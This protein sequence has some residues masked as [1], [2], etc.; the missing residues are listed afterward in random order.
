MEKVEKTICLCAIV[1][2][3]EKTLPRLINSCKGIL[4]YWVIIDTGSTDNTISVVKE[5]LSGVPGELH[6]SPFINFGH[7]R[8]ELVQ[9]A[10]GKADYL[11]LMDADMSV[12]ID[13]SFNRKNLT[14]DMYQVRYV[15]GIDFSQPLLV[16]GH[17]DWHYEGY[18]HEYI[19]FDGDFSMEKLQG[20]KVNHFYDGGSR[21]DKFNRDIK[22]CTQEIVDHPNRSRPHFYLAQ[23]HQNMGNYNDAIT[24]YQK[25]IKMGGW[26]EEIYYSLYQVGICLYLLKNFDS[27]ILQFLEANNQRPTRFEALF[28]VGQIFRERKRYSTAKMF[29]EKIIKMPYPKNDILFIHRTQQDY[30]ADFELGICN[31]WLGR[32]KDAEKYA[33]RLLNRNDVDP[34]VKKQN[35]QN[36]KFIKDKLNLQKAKKNDLIYVSMYTHGTPYEQEVKVLDASLNKYKL[37]FEIVGIRPQGSW[38]KNTQMKPQIILDIM[39][40]HNKDVVWVDADAEILSDPVFFSTIETDIAFH[41]LT[42][43][44]DKPNEFHEML[45]GTVFFRN[46]NKIRV[47]LRQWIAL[48]KQVDRP[49]GETFQ[50]LLQEDK[51][52]TR[53]DLPAEYVRIFDSEQMEG[54][55]PIIVHNQASRRF[56]EVMNTGLD[57]DNLIFSFFDEAMN[58]EDSCSVI[59]NGPFTTDLSREIDNSFVMRCNNFKTGEGF[60]SIGERVDLN[61]S[62]LFQLIVPTEKVDYPIFGVL[63]FSDTLYQQYTEAKQM[64]HAWDQNSKKLL[65]IGCTVWTY[66]DKDDYSKLFTEIAAHINAFPTVGIMGIATA[67]KLGFKRIIITGFT[68]FQSDKSHYWSDIKVRPSNHHNVEAERNLVRHWIDNDDIEYVLDEKLKENLYQDETIRHDSAK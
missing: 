14:A 54:I 64:H 22:F 53:T 56:K 46:N 37:F 51:Y 18:T 1:K 50:M 60:E 13:K 9:K 34:N 36:Y 26:D 12:I 15:G 4:D 57:P 6:E 41:I 49:D 68:F 31:Y 52:L 20:L 28:M 11:L 5:Q 44:K 30:L 35:L 19:M 39:E 21:G 55:K 65:T 8:T 67:R 58:G 48:N 29:F 23:T 33:A 59:G 17:V 27:A 2:N 7:N 43:Y 45:V 40:K 61:I 3:E 62:S 25:R 63:P 10:K 42:W 24:S 66:S 47:L 32:Y 16:S 38:I